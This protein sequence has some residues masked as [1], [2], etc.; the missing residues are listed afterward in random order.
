MAIDA[1]IYFRNQA[2]DVL[3]SVEQGLRMRDMLDKKAL[4]KKQL[5]E[6]DA[7]KEAYKA[8]TAVGEDGKAQLNRA[9]LMSGLAKIDGR[10]A[11][12]AQSKFGQEDAAQREAK[13]KQKMQHADMIARVAP[14]IKDQASYEQGLSFLAQSGVDTAQMP[15]QYD[16]G[17]V[18][19]YALASKSLQEQMQEQN[20]NKEFAQKDQEFGLKEKG[21]GLDKQKFYSDEKNKNAE[22]DFKYANIGADRAMFDKRM[23][24]DADQFNQTMGFKGQELSQRDKE[25]EAKKAQFLEERKQKQSGKTPE[26]SVAEAKQLGL[27]KLGLE[28]EKQFKK[29]VSDPSEFDPTQVGQVIDNSSGAPNWLKNDKAIESQAAQSNWIEAFLRDASG[30]AIP[31]SERGA[32]AKDFF[33][34]SGDTPE[35]V[36][37]KERMRQQKMDNARVAAG[38]GAN[39]VTGVTPD[40]VAYAEKHGISPEQA[41]AVKESR[42]SRTGA[43]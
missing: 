42:M 35:V 20:K 6:E 15:R 7:I 22:L 28:A 29:A 39:A 21:F 25:L 17:L 12:D 24:Q 1:S 14:S 38:D 19:R 11:L 30:A 43:R 37:N 4:Q 8:N 18:S 10:M 13:M 26:M 5:A 27:Y 23:A 36:A 3:G 34:Q 41:L 32:Y 40:V 9:G 2:P 16:P 31:P 33:P